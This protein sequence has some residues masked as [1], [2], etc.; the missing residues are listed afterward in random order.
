MT[1]FVKIVYLN[2][3]LAANPEAFSGNEGFGFVGY[4]VLW[5]IVIPVVGTFTIVM[6]VLWVKARHERKLH[7]LK[8]DNKPCRENTLDDVRSAKN[9]STSLNQ[10]V[11]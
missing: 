3:M 8:E 6:S 4:F 5:L 2:E 11:D 10:S 9:R 1:I 7:L